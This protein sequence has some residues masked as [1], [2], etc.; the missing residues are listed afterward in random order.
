M[1]S[2]DWMR[3]L[4]AAALLGVAAGGCSSEPPEKTEAPRPGRISG[5]LYPI[6]DTLGIEGV[7]PEEFIEL[8]K[9]TVQPV[10]PIGEAKRALEFPVDDP[11]D[12]PRPEPVEP[13]FVPGEAVVRLSFPLEE[14]LARLERLPGLRAYRFE[15][16]D[17]ATPNLLSLRF[18]HG[19]RVPNEAETADVAA[20]LDGSGLFAYAH[21]NY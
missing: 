7:L 15:A 9:E 5:R 10:T 18:R 13:S 14:T 12:A 19:D 2:M 8:A 4:A 11:A 21:P 6:A 1:K 20:R 3:G 16:G 17:W